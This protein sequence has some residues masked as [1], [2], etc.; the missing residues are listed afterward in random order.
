MDHPLSRHRIHSL[1]WNDDPFERTAAGPDSNF[2][3]AF[4]AT[5]RFC[6]TFDND[7]GSTFRFPGTEPYSSPDVSAFA[8]SFGPNSS[9]GDRSTCSEKT[10]ISSHTSTLH[11]AYFPDPGS[12]N[13]TPF[14]SRSGGARTA[15]RSLG[16][17]DNF[18]CCSRSG[19]PSASQPDY[20]DGFRGRL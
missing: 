18:P 1:R 6:S 13:G 9:R 10:S 5:P 8:G 14:P 15:S 20:T 7:T 11:F 16:T 3:A 4:R 12:G 17:D 19:A 2:L